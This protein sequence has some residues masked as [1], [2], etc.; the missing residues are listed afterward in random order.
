M[1][2]EA[3]VKKLGLIMRDCW[4]SEENLK[5]SEDFCQLLTTVPNQLVSRLNFEKFGGTLLQMAVHWELKSYMKLLLKHG[6]DPTAVP[7]DCDKFPNSPL[8]MAMMDKESMEFANIFKEF[9]ADPIPDELKL[10]RIAQICWPSGS[11]GILSEEFKDLLASLP[12]ELVSKTGVTHYG[13]LLQKATREMN[14]EV[15]RVLLQ[16]GAD[17]TLSEECKKCAG[18]SRP[19]RLEK[20]P[21]QIAE[22]EEH[23]AVLAVL[24][25]YTTSK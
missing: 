13:T 14:P 9:M 23:P 1:S 20:T 22:E 8:A 12:V 24:A 7:E 19:C 3:A 15:M 10:S 17:P 6:A 16:H 21:V 25:E 11:G 18:T 5:P 4:R 2:N